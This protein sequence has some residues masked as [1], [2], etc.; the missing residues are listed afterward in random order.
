MKGSISL[1]DLLAG[2]S[3]DQRKRVDEEFRRLKAEYELE[4]IF[5]NQ[6]EKA[7]EFANIASRFTTPRAH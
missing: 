3:E 6:A 1:N 7:R 2:M 4:Q 5:T